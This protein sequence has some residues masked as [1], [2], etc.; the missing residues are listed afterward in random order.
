[1]Q[2]IA[3]GKSKPL[4]LFKPNIKTNT[5]DINEIL[6]KGIWLRENTK[7][8]DGLAKRDPKEYKSMLVQMDLQ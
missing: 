7:Y 5:V 4:G 2:G 3:D 8:V 6:P 1:V